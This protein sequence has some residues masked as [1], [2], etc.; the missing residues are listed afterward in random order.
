MRDGGSIIVTWYTIGKEGILKKEERKKKEHL[1]TSVFF[2]EKEETLNKEERLS[3][4]RKE[5]TPTSVFF[6]EQVSQRRSWLSVPKE[7]R[8]SPS[9][10]KQRAL[11]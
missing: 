8:K 2:P 1:Y 5:G 10:E 4:K 9:E 3:K 7:T 11:T 6:P